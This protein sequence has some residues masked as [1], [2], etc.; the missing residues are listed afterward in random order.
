LEKQE[1]NINRFDDDGC[2]SSDSEIWELIP[3]NETS[4]DREIEITLVDIRQFKRRKITKEDRTE[5]HL[6][7]HT[8]LL[9][10]LSSTIL[11]NKW[12][13][14]NDLQTILFEIY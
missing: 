5:R 10:L 7:H 3:P 9:T 6:L 13:Q 8:H 1:E 14:S 12:T 2:S 4:E 11:R